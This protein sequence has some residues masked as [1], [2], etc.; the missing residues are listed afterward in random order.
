MTNKHQVS[1]YTGHYRNLFPGVQS[2][3]D[4]RQRKQEAEV[5]TREKIYEFSLILVRAG[6]DICVNQLIY[7]DIYL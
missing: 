7:A 1:R 6:N 5:S 2:G 4:S 3:S